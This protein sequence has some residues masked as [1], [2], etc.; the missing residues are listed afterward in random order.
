MFPAASLHR[1]GLVLATVASLLSACAANNPRDPL[2]PFNRSMFTF[3]DKLD[4]AVA[5][6]VAKAYVAV[7]PPMVR[8]GVS[9]FFS[10]AYDFVSSVNCLL[11]FKPQCAADNFL[12]FSFNTIFGFAGLLDIAGEMGIDHRHTDFGITLGRWGVPSGPYLVLPLLGP[13]TVRDGI[14]GRL[15]VDRNLD[16]IRRI[17]SVQQRNQ[18]FVLGLVDTRASLLRASQVFE[19]AAIDKYVFTRE[20]YLQRRRN[21]VYDGNPPDE[22]NAPAP[23]DDGDSGAAPAEPAAATASAPASAASAPAATASQPA[24]SASQPAR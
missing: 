22:E 12:R 10:N 14:A 3:N 5:Q 13:S 17:D 4:K 8:T 1:F 23:P 16:P 2:E 19:D 7:T 15:T 21:L 9:N 20:A 6:P 11:Q 24:P 18:L